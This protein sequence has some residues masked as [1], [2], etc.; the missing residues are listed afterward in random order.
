MKSVI[1]AS[2]I[3]VA[4]ASCGPP[5]AAT[6]TTVEPGHTAVAD[7]DTLT[8]EWGC[9]NGF[10]VGNPGQTSAL[11]LQFTGNELTETEIDLPDPA[12]SG[13]LIHG[14]NL[15]AN[16]C[17]DVIEANEPTP[18]EHETI[19]IVGGHLS[20]VGE[21]PEPFA[22]GTLVVEAT[23]LEVALPDGTTAVLGDITITNR[24]WGVFAG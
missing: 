4:L 11:R 5:E 24:A 18:M 2:S 1:L 20:I 16:W 7:L 14:T 10:Y 9:G 15:Y 22:G 8:E 6:S 12:W 17:D 23:D 3:L 21:I 13:Q 19:T